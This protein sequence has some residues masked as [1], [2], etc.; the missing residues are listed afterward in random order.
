MPYRQ[1]NSPVKCAKTGKSRN[2]ARKK[3]V[4]KLANFSFSQK[5]KLVLWSHFN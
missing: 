2:G 3:F 4:K 1:Y 5:V